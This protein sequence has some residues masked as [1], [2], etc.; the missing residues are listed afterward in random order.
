LNQAHRLARQIV[1]ALQTLVPHEHVV[2]SLG[3]T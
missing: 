3:E 2:V 1:T